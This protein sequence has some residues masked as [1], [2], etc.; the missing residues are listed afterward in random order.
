MTIKKSDAITLLVLS[1][2]F[3]VFFFSYNHYQTKWTA[4]QMI[5]HAQIIKEDIWETNYVGTSA[6]LSLVAEREN[7]SRIELMHGKTTLLTIE[8]LRLNGVNLILNRLGLFPEKIIITDIYYDGQIIGTLRGY[9]RD[10]S[11]YVHFLVFILLTLIYIIIKMVF[12]ITKRKITEFELKKRDLKH[13]KMLANIGDVLVIINQNGSTQYKSENIT[14]LFGW[15]PE[16]IENTSLWDM[17]HPDELKSAQETFQRLL[18]QS[19]KPITVEFRYKCRN[20][21]F[22]WIQFTGINLFHDPDIKGILGNFHDISE[23]KLTEKEIKLKNKIQ[24]AQLRLIN[25]APDLSSTTLLQKFLDEAEILTQS[26]I[27]FYHFL[28]QDE[29]II[30]LHAWSTNTMKTECNSA[31]S[32]HYPVDKAGVWSE[33]IQKRKTVIHNDYKNLKNKKGFPA[34]HVPVIRELVVPIFRDDKIVAIL[35]V[36]NKP[37]DYTPADAQTLEILSELAWETLVR[38][39]TEEKIN[40]S[41][42]KFRLAFLTS[43]DAILLTTMK[44]GICLEI[45]EGFSKTMGYPRMDVIGKSSLDLNIWKNNKDR[46]RLMSALQK[47]G[48]VE[49]FEAEFLTKSGKVR[50]GLISARVIFIENENC[51]LSICRDITEQ[52]KLE[53]QY[54]QAKKMESIGTLAGGIAHD[55]NN[56]LFPILG[57]SEMLLQ[58]LPVDD[59]SRKS[60]NAIHTSALRA[61]AL[62]NQI[63]TFSR[64]QKDE[65]KLMKIQPVL[66]EALQMLRVTMPSTIDIKQKISSECGPIKADPTQIH[67]LILNLATNALHAMEEKGGLL[68]IE[69]T[70]INLDKKNLVPPFEKTWSICPFICKRFRRG[71]TGQYS[72]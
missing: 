19:N 21:Q 27:G 41:E 35:G 65:I 23:K 32:H 72:G 37:V 34:G 14:K 47:N 4:Q 42:E 58:D 59:L 36:G 7:Y 45:N 2:C 46:D 9:H 39:K 51:L 49:N 25:E 5:K 12:E 53:L 69:L 54:R 44:D 50:L 64:Q 67:Q 20:G 28:T 10:M 60:V 6:Y 18:D 1:V 13:N 43:P 55:F 70:P 40:T 48:I 26:A 31:I 68:T 29:K 16:E 71:D 22:K 63:L 62:V 8:G 61:K 66:Q 33:C 38:K 3:A 56:M 24:S 11:F 30:S 57:H 17:I 15:K 52:R